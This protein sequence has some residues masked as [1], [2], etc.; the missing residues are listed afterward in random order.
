MRCY[1]CIQ[2]SIAYHIN[3]AILLPNASNFQYKVSYQRQK[4]R[5]KTDTNDD[6]DRS[7]DMIFQYKRA[8][9]KL[10]NENEHL[11]EKEADYND[12][13]TDKT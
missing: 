9:L 12:K 5:I 7:R 1:Y 4:A 2:K 6:L 10:A 13:S 8:I 3:K 11:I